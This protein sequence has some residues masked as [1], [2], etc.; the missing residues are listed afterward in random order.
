M[1]KLTSYDNGINIDEGGGDGYYDG[2]KEK[3]ESLWQ[4][5]KWTEQMVNLL[6]NAVYYIEKDSSSDYLDGVRRKLSVMQKIGKWKCVSKL[7]VKRGYHV[8]PQQCEDKFSDLNK[9][10]K[11]LNDVLGKGTSCKVVENPELL[12]IM[13]VSD[14]VKEEV[15]KILSSKNLFYEEM[16]SYHTG[17]RLHLPHDPEV[18][19]SLQLALG[20]RDDSEPN[21]SRQHKGDDDFDKEQQDAGA[22]DQIEETEFNRGIPRLPELSAKRS[23]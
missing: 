21:Q 2:P 18:Q 23:K 5:V 12:D 10:Y 1:K 17:N 22:D 4:R 8:S 20:S 16:C 3:R 9:R 11:R 15:K 13:N 14:K 7:M 19:R 6:I